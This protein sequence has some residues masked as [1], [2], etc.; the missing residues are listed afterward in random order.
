M[1]PIKEIKEEIKY[2]KEGMEK[3][4]LDESNIYRGWV[5]A[6]EWVLTGKGK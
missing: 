5:E 6:L 3:C 2:C 1:K 4:D